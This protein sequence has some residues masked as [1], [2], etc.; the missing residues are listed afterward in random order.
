MKKGIGPRALGSPLKQ[1]K[2][3]KTVKKGSL[4]ARALDARSYLKGEQGFI[5]DALTGGKPTRQA[6]NE[7]RIFNP[8]SS[9]ESRSDMADS[10]TRARLLKEQNERDDKGL[11]T[12]AGQKRQLDYYNSQS[13]KT[14]PNRKDRY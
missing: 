13:K 10:R 2:T 1:T 5:P 4:E 3:K 14:R 8:I 6:M 9:E 7:S 11:S 12:S